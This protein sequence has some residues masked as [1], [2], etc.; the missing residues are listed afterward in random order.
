MSM[1]TFDKQRDRRE[2][3][4]LDARWKQFRKDR[5]TAEQ[6][7]EKR[8]LDIAYRNWESAR[9]TDAERERITKALQ[10]RSDA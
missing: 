8:L 9:M 2:K 7:E 10:G 6:R 5:M 3:D 1:S 4:A